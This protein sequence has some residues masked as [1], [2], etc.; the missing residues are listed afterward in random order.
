MTDGGAFDRILAAARHEVDADRTFALA[1]IVETRGSTYRRTG[2]RLVVR[3]D[4]TWEGNISGGCLEGEIVTV[5]Q[6]VIEN[7]QPQLVSFDLTADVEAIW[8]WGLG[9]NGAIDVF[10]EP[11]SSGMQVLD[12]LDTGRKADRSSALVTVIASSQPDLDVGRHD[13]LR[14]SEEE[15][16]LPPDV[17]ATARD[18][19]RSGRSGRRR[20]QSD[21]KAEIDV[22]VEVIRPQ[23]RLLVCGAGPDAAPLVRLGRSLGWDM[24]VLDDRSALLTEDRFP[25]STT[26]IATSPKESATVAG[27]RE[28][29]AAVIMSH[30]FLRDVGY[31]QALLGTGVD[32]IGVLGPSRRLA[33]LL[34]HLVG[35]GVRPT[36][37]DLARIHGPAGLDLG[38]DGPDE[39]ALSVAAQVMAV[40]RGRSGGSMARLD[41]DAVQQADE[42]V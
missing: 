7:R 14:G 6:A 11:S 8:G 28:R 42:A 40:D 34:E 5:A 16:L 17:A 10:V 13:L 20:V 33:R 21:E 2:A 22:L 19:V 4:G 36:P 12:L 3:S 32:Y 23:R 1:T 35:L 39:I 38:A 30:N 31:L 26:L 29:T 27:V 41:G 15:P 9:C 37:D 25:A 18:V 24:V